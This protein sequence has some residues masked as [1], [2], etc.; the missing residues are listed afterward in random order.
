MRGKEKKEMA[1][2]GIPNPIP[3]G[4][5][6]PALMQKVGNGFTVSPTSGAKRG[7]VKYHG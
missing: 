3:K 2:S 5:G 6:D 7:Q 1:S 4:D